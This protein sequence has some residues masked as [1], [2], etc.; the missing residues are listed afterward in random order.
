MT[1]RITRSILAALA[2]SLAVPAF[3]AAPQDEAGAPTF[4]ALDGVAAEALDA[5][6][7]DAIHGALSGQELFARLLADAQLIPNP[8]V[9]DRLIAFLTAN[10]AKLVAYFNW[11]LSFRR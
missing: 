1:Q 10:E 3:A 6:E 9:R 8:A 7:L 5:G 4:A 2:V 11:I